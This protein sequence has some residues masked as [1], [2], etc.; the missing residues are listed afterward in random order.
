MAERHNDPEFSGTIR[1]MA[2]CPNCSRK[3]QSDTC[4]KCGF[5][6]EVTKEATVVPVVIIK[7]VCFRCNRSLPL[8][9]FDTSAKYADGLTKQCRAC[10]QRIRNYRP[11][12][13]RR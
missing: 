4:Y 5:R 9:Y 13:G 11:S 6:A 2:T 7:K 12:Q 1:G 10:L 8:A 3:L